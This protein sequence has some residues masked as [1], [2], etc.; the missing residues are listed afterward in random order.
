MS[1]HP[2][3]LMPAKAAELLT[4]AGKT[5]ITEEMILNDI[6]AGAP[7]NADGTINLVF[8]ASWTVRELANGGK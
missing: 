7:V 5:A 2:A 3:S 8:Y 4:K 6:A 1:D